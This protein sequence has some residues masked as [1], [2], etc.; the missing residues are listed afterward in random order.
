M[1]SNSDKKKQKLASAL[2][3]NLLR[4]KA[5]VIEKPKSKDK[6]KDLEKKIIESQE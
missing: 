2:R 3:A 1:L 6:S 5:V 4:R